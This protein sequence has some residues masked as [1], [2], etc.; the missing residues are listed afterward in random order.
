MI[1][2]W[3]SSSGNTKSFVRRIGLE[4]IEI[5][6]SGELVVDE[7]FVLITPTFADQTGKGAVPKP[8]IKFLNKQVNRSNML[9]VIGGGNRNFGEYFAIGG[10]AVSSK[11]QVPLLYLFELA[12]TDYDVE[13]VRQGILELWNK[14]QNIQD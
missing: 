10:K 11:C 1:V 5:P 6:N 14:N 13:R 9:G 4:S 8:V 7:K 3:S 12:G 2:Y